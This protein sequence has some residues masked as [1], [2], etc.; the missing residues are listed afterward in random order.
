MVVKRQAP[1]SPL[2]KS[3]LKQVLS[4]PTIS[5]AHPALRDITNSAS[6]TNDPF[7]AKSLVVKQRRTSLRQRTIKSSFTKI[8]SPTEVEE[9]EEPIVKKEEETLSKLATSVFP[10]TSDDLEGEIEVAAGGLP[11]EESDLIGPSAVIPELTDLSKNLVPSEEFDRR[12]VIEVVE[13]DF[14]AE[15]EAIKSE[16]CE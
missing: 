16:D 14:S 12:C 13:V 10:S 2:Q 3:P 11:V 1:S 5:S 4:T 7:P 6:T 9:Q 15:A 8:I